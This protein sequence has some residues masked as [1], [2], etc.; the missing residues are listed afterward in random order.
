MGRIGTFKQRL[1]DLGAKA[2]NDDLATQAAALS[3]YSALSFAPLVL[4]ILAALATIGL[5]LEMEFA[6]QVE[7]LMG[8][9]AAKTFRDIV[10][11][12]EEHP[13]FIRS[14]NVFGLLALF[15]SASGIFAQL[16]AALNRIFCCPPVNPSTSWWRDVLNMIAHRAV[17][18]VVVLAFIAISI[19]SL[20]LSTFLA[21]LMNPKL[22]LIGQLMHFAATFAIFSLI[23]TAL[24]RWL[25]DQF[26]P[27]RASWIGGA[28]TAF[29][30]MTGKVIITLLLE[31]GGY[32]LAY[33]AAGS[34]I[35]LLVWVYYSSFIIFL[36]AEIAS[37]GGQPL[38]NHLSAK[39][40]ATS[41][42]K[43]SRSYTWEKPTPSTASNAPSR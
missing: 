1:W 3:F 43:P 18:L 8:A 34:L 4:L 16:R 28:A 26:V 11:Y 14:A 13:E 36:G 6:S 32:D 21:L 17:S 42:T 19:A 9:G 30:F 23:F 38:W 39:T 7:K 35:V 22:A 41:T 5:N 10:A 2:V 25:P 12:A 27:W 15:F 37:I 40:A 24:F 31:R 20:L 29:L 33:G